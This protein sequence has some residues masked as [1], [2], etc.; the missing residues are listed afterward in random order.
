MRKDLLVIFILLV[1]SCFAQ[2]TEIKQ[3]DSLIRVNKIKVRYIYFD[4]IVPKAIFQ[5]SMQKV[6]MAKDS[7]DI[8]G[9]LVKSQEFHASDV[10][11]QPT[12]TTEYKYDSLNRLTYSKKNNNPKVIKSIQAVDY[13]NP[14]IFSL[15]S[16]ISYQP[17][18]TI[19]T[20]EYDKN[21][22]LI[23]CYT[24]DSL[25]DGT[26]EKNTEEYQYDDNKRVIQSSIMS[27]S[28]KVKEEKVYTYSPKTILKK[29]YNSNGDLTITT[30]E[31]PEFRNEDT[32]DYEDGRRR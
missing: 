7:F 20:Y 1:N 23:K 27:S 21:N 10:R 11:P 28:G 19:N 17:L 16:L 12:A 30:L 14:T 29:N 5:G 25:F 22:N 9:N 8:S 31:E 2:F 18:Q 6:L 26:I 32:A 24:V 4:I 13:N 15:K 3:P